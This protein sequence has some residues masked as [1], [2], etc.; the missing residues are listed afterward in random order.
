M[1]G[2]YIQIGKGILGEDHR[3]ENYHHHQYSASWHI[4]KFMGM[5]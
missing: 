4:N 3:I 5:A 1:V 2:V